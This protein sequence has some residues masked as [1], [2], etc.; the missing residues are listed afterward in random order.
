M[1]DPKE[2]RLL[3]LT[4][5]EKMGDKS[6]FPIPATLY[7]KDENGFSQVSITEYEMMH[8]PVITKS[9][10]EIYCKEKRLFVRL[11]RPFKSFI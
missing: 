11:N 2:L 10:T 1:I 8:I 3:K 5:V 6:V 4:E 9:L 7:R